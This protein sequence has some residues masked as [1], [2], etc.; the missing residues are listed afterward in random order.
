MKVMSSW[1][2]GTELVQPMGRVTSQRAPK[3]VWKVV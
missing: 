2:I 3:G 1:K